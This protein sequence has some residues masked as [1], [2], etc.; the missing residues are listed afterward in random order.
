MKITTAICDVCSHPSKENQLFELT[1]SG[2]ITSELKEEKLKEFVKDEEKM[3]G[4]FS[5]MLSVDTDYDDPHNKKKVVSFNAEVCEKCSS[6]IIE[7]IVS[8]R[9]SKE[10][11]I[12]SIEKMFNREEA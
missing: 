3:R 2:R 4:F 9:L 6:K 7:S 11:E 5:S 1:I 8:Y 10:K 12:S